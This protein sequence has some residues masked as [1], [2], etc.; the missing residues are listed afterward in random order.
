MMVPRLFAGC[1][2][3]GLFLCVRNAS[4]DI[5]VPPRPAPAPATKTTTIPVQIKHADLKGEG[6]G[7]QAK[8]VLPASLRDAAAGK[9]G[10]KEDA[11]PTQRSIVAAIALSLAAVSMVFVLRGKKL[12]TTSK[13]AILAVGG[14][15]AIFGAA[16]ADIAIPGQKRGPRPIPPREPLAKSM[17]I[18]EFSSDVE[19]AILT[20]QK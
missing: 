7:V 3:F 13:A 15:L 1:L 11:A 2:V 10:L 12:N 5:K 9:V 4:A 8:I 16:Q 18:V 14:I 19:E 6:D 17:I 20:L